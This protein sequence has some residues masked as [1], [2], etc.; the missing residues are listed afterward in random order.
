[1]KNR[2][3]ILLIMSV[4]LIAGCINQPQASDEKKVTENKEDSMIKKTNNMMKENDT[5]NT[6]KTNDS[7]MEKTADSMMK[8]S[9]YKDFTKVDYD[10]AKEEG[11][12]IYLEFAA[13]WCP[14]CQAQHP[15]IVDAFENLNNQ[16]V[17]GFRVNYK[18]SRTDQ[19]EV[20]LARQFG[21]TYQHT[22]IILDSKGSIVNR[23]T[24]EWSSE[25]IVEELNKVA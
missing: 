15:K 11:K 12:I 17:V 22:R 14:S 20:D 7:M 13:D 16:N 5:E 2:I 25:Q 6:E 24:G 23:A 21:I 18:D 3:L 9:E 8:K 4:L 1:M 19:D 10:K